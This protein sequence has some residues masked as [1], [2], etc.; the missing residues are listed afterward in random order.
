[1]AN[2]IVLHSHSD[3]PS[4]DQV[5]EEGPPSEDEGLYHNESYM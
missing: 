1:M 2:D 4:Q 5:A 3:N